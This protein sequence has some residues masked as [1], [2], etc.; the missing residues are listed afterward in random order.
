[1]IETEAETIQRQREV[2]ATLRKDLMQHRAGFGQMFHAH[3]KVKEQ[4]EAARA[5]VRGAVE[6]LDVSS[7]LTRQY[8]YAAHD[9]LEGE[10]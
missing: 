1:M 9:I 6:S 5:E 2:I 8:V 7:A 4:L 10:S 3:R